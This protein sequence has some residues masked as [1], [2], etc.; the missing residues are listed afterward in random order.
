M[1]IYDNLTP[2]NDEITKIQLKSKLSRNTLVNLYL[3]YTGSKDSTPIKIDGTEY[4][5]AKGVWTQVCANYKRDNHE[6]NVEFNTEDNKDNIQ[7]YT[8]PSPLGNNDDSYLFEPGPNKFYDFGDSR[9]SKINLN[10]GEPLFDNN[11]NRLH[12]GNGDD[13]SLGM[14]FW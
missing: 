7:C 11:T 8:G 1:S 10:L 3:K 4:T 6:L 5:L 9:L 13:V 2:G 14:L 12:I